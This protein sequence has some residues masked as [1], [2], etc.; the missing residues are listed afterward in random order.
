MFKSYFKL[1]L[2]SLSKDKVGSTIEVFGLGIGLA[3]CV[4]I[5]LFVRHEWSF[6]QFHSRSDDIH[7]LWMKE[8]Y[9]GDQQIFNSITPVVLG[10]TLDE[11]FPEIEDVVRI[12]VFTDIV[13]RG[14]V[15]MMSRSS[16]LTT[17]VSSPASGSSIS[18]RHRQPHRMAASSSTSTCRPASCDSIFSPAMAA[19]SA[20]SDLTKC[21]SS[22]P[23]M[24]SPSRRQRCS[25]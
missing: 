17:V 2:R 18:R 15:S 22:D 9:G 3:C 14:E 7:R 4:L 10:A 24:P 1:A 5:L 8:D 12:N 6:D 16:F 23:P 20:S 11:T 19:T 25:A 21:S 13:E